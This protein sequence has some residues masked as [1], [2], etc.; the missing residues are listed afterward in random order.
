MTEV[1]LDNMSEADAA[2]AIREAVAE[3]NYVVHEAV[4]NMELLVHMD[5]IAEDLTTV[6]DPRQVLVPRI[7]VI[8]SKPF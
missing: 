1:N 5:L 2:H 6:E 8:V 3:L 4:R 7:T